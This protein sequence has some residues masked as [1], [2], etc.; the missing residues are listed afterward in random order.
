MSAQG[1]GELSFRAGDRI[2]VTEEGG[3][4]DW[5]GGELNGELGFF[6]SSFCDIVVQDSAPPPPPPPPPAASTLKAPNT[7]DRE[8]LVPEFSDLSIPKA[9]APM[10]QANPMH[11][12]SILSGAAA[13]R[14][15]GGDDEVFI[16]L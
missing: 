11:R 7:V 5:W 16:L 3:E 2:K 4:G 6:P 14:T 1:E 10:S 8:S 15:I 12:S 9:G 13:S